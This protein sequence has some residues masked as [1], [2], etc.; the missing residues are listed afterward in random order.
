MLG[1]FGVLEND[2]HIF[3]QFEL[4]ALRKLY[5]KYPKYSP[6]LKYPPQ[7]EDLTLMLPERTRL[8]QVVETLSKGDNNISKVILKDLYKGS[9][10]FRIWYQD[11][12][13]TLTNKEVDLIRK[14]I[15]DKLKKT[16]GIDL[17]S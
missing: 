14:V 5:T 11:P 15:L 17:K 16:F 1:E 8:G 2:E 3:Y 13:K 9:A 12:L 6:V 7:I 10:T 4:E